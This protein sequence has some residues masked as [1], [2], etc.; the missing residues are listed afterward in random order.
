MPAIFRSVLDGR[1]EVC[2]TEWIGLCVK[3]DEF[4][5]E[6]RRCF[7]EGESEY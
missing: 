4:L 1:E 2:V 7:F 3:L 5:H 6:G